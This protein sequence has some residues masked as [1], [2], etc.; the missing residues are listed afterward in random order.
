MLFVEF[1]SQLL[2]LF[3]WD[4][5]LDVRNTVHMDGALWEEHPRLPFIIAWA[6]PRVAAVLLACTDIDT[7]PA[8][9][10]HRAEAAVCLLAPL[11][12]VHFRDNP[13][14]RTGRAA[15][16]LLRRQLNRC[17]IVFWHNCFRVCL[18]IKVTFACRESN[19]CGS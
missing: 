9:G 1:E 15:V 13:N 8:E 19:F 18:V 12:S 17:H 7:S 5:A 6:V 11:W 16:R 14:E 10:F 4:A 3:V 2:G